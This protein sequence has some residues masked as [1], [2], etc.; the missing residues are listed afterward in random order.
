[1]PRDKRRPTSQG[2]GS[3]IAKG[4]TLGAKNGAKESTK[5]DASPMM[6]ITRP[7]SLTEMVVE[8]LR[9]RII[10]GRL[11]LGEA[12][13]ENALAAELGIS[14][15]PVREAL[16]QLKLEKLVDVLP[17]RGTYVFR[18]APEQVTMI[19]ELREVLEVSAAASAVAR[20]HAPLVKRMSLIFDEMRAAF[21]RDDNAAYGVLDGEYHQALID[22]CGNP[23]ISDA[24]AQVGFRTQALR[25]R[26]SDEAGLNRISFK[27]HREML[28]LIK[29]REVAPLQ[30]LL[31]THINQTR[32][33]Y[34]DVLERRL[35]A[36]SEAERVE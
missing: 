34:L 16:L 24:Y 29:A 22:L 3:P 12:L 21:E 2:G 30:K 13:S 27:D 28:K 15:T 8:E 17:Q 5:S 35:L 33:M 18:M 31:R 9:K 14:K 23:Y 32:Q 6:K 11:Q 36:E 26:L 20:N 19:C 10:D 4:A 7:K 1:M 25:A